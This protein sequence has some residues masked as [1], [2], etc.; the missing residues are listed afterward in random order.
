MNG[1]NICKYLKGVRRQI[2][3]TNGIKLEIP[4]C[5]FEGECRGTCPQ[6]EAEVKYLEKKLTERRTLAKK[7]AIIGVAAGMSMAS[8]LDASAQSTS[9]TVRNCNLPPDDSEY[10]DAIS[11][12][13]DNNTTI[14]IGATPVKKITE[15][16]QILM[17]LTETIIIGFMPPRL[18]EDI[19]TKVVARPFHGTLTTLPV[20]NS[21]DKMTATAPQFPGGNTALQQFLS[22]NIIY[23]EDAKNQQIE[24]TVIIQMR[25][26]ESGKVSHVKVKTKV[27]PSLDAEAVRLVNSMPDWEPATLDGNCIRTKRLI[28]VSFSLNK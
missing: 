21:N 9:D 17:G 27:H 23:P 25:I 14:T 4:E 8:A 11:R 1:K 6:C 5:T 2:A 13:M 16:S 22:E 15:E 26:S 28:Y 24:G 3:E 7:I 12:E 10:Q 20:E 19:S 18:T